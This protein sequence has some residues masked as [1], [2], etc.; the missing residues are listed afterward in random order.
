MLLLLVIFHAVNVED[1]FDSVSDHGTV[2][3]VVVVVVAAAAGLF[4]LT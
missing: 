1:G 3:V 2:G 4:S